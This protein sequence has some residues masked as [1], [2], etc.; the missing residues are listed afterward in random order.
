MPEVLFRL[1]A[2]SNY[3]HDCTIGRFGGPL[4][5]D[6][7]QKALREIGAPLDDL[8]RALWEDLSS[9]DRAVCFARP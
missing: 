2:T 6:L 4:Q 3:P 5:Y 7:S 1:R 8:R 9:C